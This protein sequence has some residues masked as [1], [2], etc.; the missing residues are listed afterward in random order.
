[1]QM[2]QHSGTANLPDARRRKLLSC[3]VAA[4]PVLHAYPVAAARRGLESFDPRPPAPSLRLRATD[5][6]VY[7]LQDRIG[8]V[9]LVNFW[10]IWC[11]PCKVEMP[12]LQAL[13]EHMAP[14]G[15]EVWGVALGDDPR[16]V[17]EYGAR[18]GLSFPLLPDP[19][20]SV[21][22]RWSVA[23]MPTTDIVDKRGRVAF[24]MIGDAAW[25]AAPMR[26]RL[27]LLTLE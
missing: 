11:R 8:R 24:R 3:L 13:F 4:I 26:R 19:E 12:T 23:V 5:G 17:A 14:R 27:R 15:L 20:E 18:N 2:F 6:R 7:D 1:M 10:S 16:Q 25:N 9:V 22:D 21:S